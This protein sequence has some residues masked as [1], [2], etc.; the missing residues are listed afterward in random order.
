MK[1]LQFGCWNQLKE[2]EGRCDI[3]NPIN[4]LSRVMKTL[5]EYIEFSHPNY[6]IVSG[7]N[8]YTEKIE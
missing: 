5:N 1:F 4:S 6:L 8:Y 3:K 7:D 2:K